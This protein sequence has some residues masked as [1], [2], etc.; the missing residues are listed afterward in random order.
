MKG[1]T[2]KD[3]VGLILNPLERVSETLERKLGL[4]SVII[5]S[6][7]SM[8]GTG[9]FVIPALAMVEMGGGV[10]PVGG[11]WL[12]FLLAGIVI[13]PA[14]ISK[15]ELATAMPSSG[16]AYVYIEKSFG[17]QIGTVLGVGLWATTMFKSAFALLGFKA[18]LWVLEEMFDVKINIE[19]AA[20][21]LLVLIV[22]INILG[23]K[24]IKKVQTPIVLVSVLFLAFI[25][26]KALLTVEMH[27]GNA[28][29]TDAFGNGIVS[30]AETSAFVFV[31]YAGVTKIAAIGGEIKEPE[32]NIPTGLLASLVISS[33]I[34]VIF[35]IVMVSA[36]DP[37]QYVNEQGYPREDPVYV[38][39][40]SVAGQTFAQISAFLAITMLTGMALAGV[41]AT[42]RFPFA[43]ARDNLLP[44]SIE[45]VHPKYNTPHL[46][47]I[48]TG[49]AM[50]FCIS[51][52]PVK[53]IAKLASGF[54]IMI[55]IMI[56][57]CVIV[58][59]TSSKS[60]SWYKPKW[61][62]PFF[63]IIQIL[64]ILVSIWLI[65]L[66]GLKAIIGAIATIIIGLVIYHSYGKK[67]VEY[68]IT[69][70]ETFKLMFTN[71]NQAEKRRFY[72]AFHAADSTNKGHLNLNEFISAMYSLQLDPELNDKTLRRYFHSAD[73]NSDGVVDVEEFL[74]S[75]QGIIE[76]E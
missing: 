48:F 24:Q 69:P 29:S 41:M 6:L 25:C 40:D 54:K 49:L 21:I 4:F 61:K 2:P 31:A 3:L 42:S 51:F 58:L 39:V 9:L 33:L 68:E 71:P 37:S 62:S 52:L 18:Y 22:I 1:F 57:C 8:L 19:I 76:E 75:I 46:S 56:N 66:M 47:I 60:H 50:G 13:L 32:K 64:G 15:S 34:Y 16:G 44:Q 38:F 45:N 70:W 67:N 17:P 27:W 11:I 7:A 59:R 23:V 72:A 14:A 35:S 73:L 55:F 26:L 43:M 53:D 20:L 12:A 5:I 10:N 74:I 63:P 30:V 65:I 36:V 28:F